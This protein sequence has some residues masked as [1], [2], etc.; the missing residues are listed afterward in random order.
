MI[1]LDKSTH[2]EH[3][4]QPLRTSI[5]QCKIANTFLTGYNGIFKDTNSN[6][7]FYFAKSITDEDDFVQKTK[8]P[9]AYEIQS[10][11]N[12]NKRIFTD[13]ERVT[14]TNYPF[15]IKP[16]FSTL[17]SI[18]EISKREPIISFLPNDCMRNVLG[19][20]AVTLYEEY[21]LSHNPVDIPSFDKFFP[22]VISLKE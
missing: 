21:N 9:A 15:T 10:L 17:G 8:P 12:E 5:M 19:F 2:K 13:E 4:S 22:S 11:N 14:E 16:N 18:I 20:N 1:V 6:K 7:N 3:L